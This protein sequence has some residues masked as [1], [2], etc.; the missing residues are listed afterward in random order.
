M[1]TIWTLLTLLICGAA[2]ADLPISRLTQPVSNPLI[3]C[4]YESRRLEVTEFIGCFS[5]KDPGV[6]TEF[7]V[8]SD[9]G[10]DVYIDGRKMLARLYRPQ[11]LQTAAMSFSRFFIPIRDNQH[12]VIRVV[13]SNVIYNGGKDPDGC[14][15]DVPNA[16]FTCCGYV[17]LDRAHDSPE[18]IK[19]KEAEAKRVE[20]ENAKK[21]EENRKKLL[22]QIEVE[23]K[24][25]AEAKIKAEQK[26]AEAKKEQEKKA[27][28]AKEKNPK[29]NNGVGNGVDPQPPGNPPVNDGPGT[30][31]GNPGNKGGAKK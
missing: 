29:G 8:I 13:Y 24:K 18:T 26:N 3:N 23:A 20:A 6:T 5:V 7:R 25:V 17:R 22:A 11:H 1:R 2:S 30:S 4:S 14:T 19:V 15:L 12:H 27:K 10:C 31:P 9:D 28:E 16:R 21:Q